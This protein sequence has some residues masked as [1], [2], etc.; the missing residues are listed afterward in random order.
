MRYVLR[1]PVYPLYRVPLA[2]GFPPGSLKGELGWEGER[3]ISGNA[4]GR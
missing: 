4:T 1:L 2:A 3:E